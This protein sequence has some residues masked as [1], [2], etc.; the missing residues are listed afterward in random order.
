MPHPLQNFAS[1]RFCVEQLGQV[2][3]GSGAGVGDGSASAKPHPRQNFVP[4]RFAVEQFGQ[5]IS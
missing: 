2:C 4:G 3:A 1:G 5:V